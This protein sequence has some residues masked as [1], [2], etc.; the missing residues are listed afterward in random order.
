M[1]VELVCQKSVLIR[2]TFIVINAPVLQ[3]AA[4][5]SVRKVTVCIVNHV[6]PN[7][8]CIVICARTKSQL[9]HLKLVLNV[10]QNVYNA[11]TVINEKLCLMLRSKFRL[12][13]VANVNAIH[14]NVRAPMKQHKD[15]VTHV[16]LVIVK[17]VNRN[18]HLL[19]LTCA[20]HVL[21][22]MDQQKRL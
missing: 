20:I 9:C 8:L 12:S 10:M 11:K 3:K 16:R 4:K 22:K 15:V 21:R 13:T 5:I 7:G 19:D 2:H 18:L 14:L 6:C 1:R 17:F